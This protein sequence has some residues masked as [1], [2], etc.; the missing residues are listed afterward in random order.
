MLATLTKEDEGNQ[1]VFAYYNKRYDKALELLSA[2]LEGEP[3]NTK[4]YFYRAAARNEL[5]EKQLAWLD[6]SKAIA[7]D[8]KFAEAYYGRAGISFSTDQFELGVADYKKVIE[9]GPSFS[10]RAHDSLAQY[11]IGKKEFEKAL[12]H[13]QESVK[14]IDSIPQTWETLSIVLSKLERLPEAEEA[15]SMAEQL[16]NR[17]TKD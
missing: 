4:Y 6:F 10:H 8:P 12:N 13:A 3:K 9:L 2:A 11:Y 15:R 16:A 14:K 5:G 17:K 7:F 1:G